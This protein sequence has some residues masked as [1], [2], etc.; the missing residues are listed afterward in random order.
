MRDRLDPVGGVEKGLGFELG[1]GKGEIVERVDVHKLRAHQRRK[2]L[3]DGQFARAGI[4]VEDEDHQILLF[5]H[6]LQFRVSS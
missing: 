3:P 1:Q 2:R 5:W 6:S 4:A